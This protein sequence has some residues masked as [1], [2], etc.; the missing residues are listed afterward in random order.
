MGKAI[1]GVFANDGHDVYIVG[2][3]PRKADVAAQELA[4]RGPGKVSPV[5]TAEE[6]ARKTDVLVLATWYAVSTSIAMDLRDA[7]RNKIVI[8]ISNPFNATFDGLITDH[9]TSAADELQRLLNGSALVKS[10]NTTFAPTLQNKS[11]GG[12]EVDV[13]LA[14]DHNH[15]KAEVA[16]LIGSAGLRPID[17]GG[18]ANA[19]SLERLALLLVELQ[20]RYG[21]GFQ[22]G[23][24]F[25]PDQSLPFPAAPAD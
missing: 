17:A 8:D 24:K 10:F 19:A 1:A 11:F 20:G 13:F 25:L 16:T 23:L 3:D 22:A 5:S 6:A 15:A 21:L 7:L 9:G 18:L 4:S 14:S 2:S 12:T